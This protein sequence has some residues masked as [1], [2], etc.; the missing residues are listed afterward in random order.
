[1][2]N[3]DSEKIGLL[4]NSTARSWRNVLDQR[5]K[6][7]GFTQGKWS[8]LVHLANSPEPLTQRDL[9]ARMGVEEPTLAGVLNRLQSDGWIK[10]KASAS[11]RRCKT[12]HLEPKSKKIIERIFSAAQSLRHELIAEIAPND[13]QVCMRVLDDIRRK[14]EHVAASP[15][16]QRALPTGN[17]RKP[18]ATGPRP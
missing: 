5:L 11:D 18:R 2:T 7:L 15:A 16:V 3:F 10:R 6:P 17:G 12:V 4:L 1:M 14:T 8:A 9:A 13:L